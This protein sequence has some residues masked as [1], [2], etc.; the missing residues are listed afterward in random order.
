MKMEIE[1]KYKVEDETKWK[2]L[3]Q[4]PRLTHMMK[5]PLWERPMLAVY[6]DTP[7]GHLRRMGAAYRVRLEGDRYVATIKSQSEEGQG[8]LSRRLE[9]NVVQPDELPRP[10]VFLRGDVQSSD[11]M[12]LLIP[13]LKLLKEHGVQEMGRTDFTRYGAEIQWQGMRADLCLDK[14]H[15]YANKRQSPIC[16]M[17]L[18]LLE[19]TKQQLE[20]LGGEFVKQYDLCPEPR[21]KYA[22]ILMLLDGKE[23][24]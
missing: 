22:R 7:G 8:A 11:A 9:W 20:Q 10:D 12:D 19:G 4:S 6:Y 16:E 15:L 13:I 21:S 23:V 2:S 24:D 17:E 5:E 14:G 3:K 1:L 18:E